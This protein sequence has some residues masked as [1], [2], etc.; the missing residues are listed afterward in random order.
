MKKIIEIDITGL[1]DT[2]NHCVKSLTDRG[3]RT[4]EA[5]VWASLYIREIPN[6]VN[7]TSEKVIEMFGVNLLHSKDSVKHFASALMRGGLEFRLEQVLD[8]IKLQKALDKV[9]TKS[10]ISLNGDMAEQ[11]N[12]L[13]EA[14]YWDGD[15]S[16]QE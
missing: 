3:F 15:D 6:R 16:H 5:E 12:E 1:E 7:E 8:E 13:S 14:D 2:F 4:S 11:F 9:L 10:P